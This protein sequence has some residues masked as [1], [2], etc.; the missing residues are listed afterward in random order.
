ME[1]IMK[2]KSELVD[3]NITDLFTGVKTA[4]YEHLGWFTLKV[5]YEEV[6][7]NQLSH[8]LDVLF[9]DYFQH[10]ERIGMRINDMP[11]VAT[12]DNKNVKAIMQKLLK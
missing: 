9:K 8:H 2:L 6:N 5:F 4:T 12:S 10:S 7:V 1:V 3:E 11:Y